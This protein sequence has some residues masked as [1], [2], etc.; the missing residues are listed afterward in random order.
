MSQHPNRRLNP[1]TENVVAFV[2]I[3]SAMTYVLLQ[4]A[5]TKEY[6]F[7]VATIVQLGLAFL[8]FAVPRR[9]AWIRLTLI[10]FSIAGVPLLGAEV[11][12][13]RPTQWSF[14]VYI[15]AG[16][17][18]SL[19]LGGRIGK[20]R[21]LPTLPTSIQFMVSF[22]VYLPEGFTEVDRNWY[23]HKGHMVVQRIYRNSDDGS[24][25]WLE[26][27]DGALP[28]FRLPKNKQ[29]IDKTIM[30]KPVHFEQEVLR[31][32]S[33]SGRKRELPF[34]E[35]HWSSNGVNHNIRSDGL[36]LPGIEK[37]IESMKGD[38]A[39][40]RYGDPPTSS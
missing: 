32:S 23:R 11:G 38:P 28:E 12:Y 14:L 30:D 37:V 40:R 33:R 18:I 34:I 36:L 13:L 9:L 25:I 22:P 6:Q 26:E 2:L 39:G 21:T 19:L 24:L 15:A 16:A 1:K 5:P 8:T 35:A 27:S 31:P 29:A 20:N 10:M 3:L 4:Y 7:W 17:G